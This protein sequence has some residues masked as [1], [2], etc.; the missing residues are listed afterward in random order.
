M[1]TSVVIK[2][3][4]CPC[5]L[6]ISVGCRKLRG[7][8]KK[9]HRGKAFPKIW[10]ATVSLHENGKAPGQD[11]AGWC[12]FPLNSLSGKV[13]LPPNTISPF[14]PSPGNVWP[15]WAWEEA[16]LQR[17]A[18]GSAGQESLGFTPSGAQG[19]EQ[20]S[21]GDTTKSL[22]TQWCFR[23]RKFRINQSKRFL[24]LVGQ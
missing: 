12:S 9:G 19:F 23:T 10:R 6:S 13:P 17:T 2:S 15:P 8:P 11:S 5:S 3:Q 14:Q 18:V 21:S 7:E 22:V 1:A 4:Q 20:T 24:K 16:A